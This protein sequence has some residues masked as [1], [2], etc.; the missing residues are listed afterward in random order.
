MRMVLNYVIVYEI[1]DRERRS[2]GF[3][4]PKVA[5][6]WMVEQYKLNPSFHVKRVEGHVKW[7]RRKK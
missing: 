5:S 4:N 3:T 1:G 7:E 2:K 6:K